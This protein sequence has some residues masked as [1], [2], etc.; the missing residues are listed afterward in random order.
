MKVESR[1]S[2]VESRESK[3]ESR[4]WRVERRETRV[5]SRESRVERHEHRLGGDALRLS[6]VVGD[7]QDGDLLLQVQYQLLDMTPQEFR[8]SVANQPYTT[9]AWSNLLG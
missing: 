2:R 7:Y 3:V 9:A 4:E 6:H 5:E 8:K 1:G